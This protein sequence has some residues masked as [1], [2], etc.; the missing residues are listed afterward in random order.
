MKH[1]SLLLLLLFIVINIIA[2][3]NGKTDPMIFSEFPMLFSDSIS[4]YTS[5]KGV[6]ELIPDKSGINV[7][8]FSNVVELGLDSLIDVILR[9]NADNL[10]GELTEPV[11]ISQNLITGK[12]HIMHIEALSEHSD[13]DYIY[14][15]KPMFQS[16]DSARYYSGIEQMNVTGYFGK[17]I[18]VCLLDEGINVQGEHINNASRDILVWNQKDE[19][20]PIPAGFYYGEEIAAEQIPFYPLYD[21][22]GHGTAILSL[23]ASSDSINRGML[24]SS[25]IIGVNVL[26]YE[27]NI[28]DG[29]KFIIDRCASENRSFIVC[30]PLNHFWGRHDGRSALDFAIDT[31]FSDS[32][33]GRGIAVSAGNL[34]L[35]PIHFSAKIESNADNGLMN[36]KHIIFQCVDDYRFDA[37]IVNIDDILFRFLYVYENQLKYTQWISPI[38]STKAYFKDSM[39]SFAYGYNRNEKQLHITVTQKNSQRFA[40]EFIIDSI[41]DSITGYV[42]QGGFIVHDGSINCISGDSDN[43][44]AIPGLASQAI[45]SGVFVSRNSIPG[46]TGISDTVF[47]IPQWNSRGNYKYV[48]PDVY[49]PGKFICTYEE[50]PISSIYSLPNMKGIYCGSSFAAAVTAGAMGVVLGT[51]RLMH[52]KK[53]NYLIRQGSKT[54]P[55]IP[56]STSFFEGF[57]YLDAYTSFLATRVEQMGISARFHIV[58]NFIELKLDNPE[59]RFRSVYKNGVPISIVS[60]YMALDIIPDMGNNIYQ[61][62]F[63][64]REKDYCLIDTFSYIIENLST[65]YSLFYD[66]S[67]RQLN[68]MPEKPG[69]YF[70]RDTNS[71]NMNK[72]IILK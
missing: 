1:F 29:M 20:L 33:S 4:V 19:R 69:I 55:Y 64:F 60:D 5:S 21:S 10:M 2:W 68:N 54:I 47:Q 18:T 61:I 24:S 39:L 66:I 56:G 35:S 15:S 34:G 12:I 48:K 38:S 32:K 67:G 11:K 26:P 46:I 53:L 40:V 23:L 14:L 9:G 13:I 72:F 42:A 25:D 30:L 70:C 45:T 41:E 17:E 36:N 7:I 49:A 8:H 52:T 43:T 22:T 62:L 51:D 3:D 71:R 58:N 59:C 50:N 27:K 44:I 65:K 16:A 6:Y 37:D 57:G 28:I 31:L 63:S